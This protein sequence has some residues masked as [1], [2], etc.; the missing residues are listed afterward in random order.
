MGAITRLVLL[1]V[2]LSSG[3]VFA[4]F[5]GPGSDGTM[6]IQ[7]VNN[8]HGM[9]NRSVNVI[10]G[11][12]L[13]GYITR[14]I[15]GEINPITREPMAVFNFRDNTGNVA[16]RIYNIDNFKVTPDNLIIVEL[17]NYYGISGYSGIIERI[18]R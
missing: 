13:K 11:R 3:H 8:L 10:K 1:L 9:P 4:Q 7:D 14:Q 5:E 15:S 12:K 17:I 2:L 18:V 16:L 6:T